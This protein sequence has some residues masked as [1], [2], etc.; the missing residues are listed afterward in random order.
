LIKDK[1]FCLKP[2]RPY[3]VIE[4]ITY[5]SKIISIAIPLRSNINIRF[6][7]NKN[8]YI[9]VNATKHT[10]VEKG[11]VSGWQI[12]KMIPI[13]RG[14]FFETETNNKNIIEAVKI[15]KK[16]RKEL[17]VKCRILLNKFAQNKKIYGAIDFDYYVILIFK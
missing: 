5:K 13:K 3:Y 17:L 10:L 14:L 4:K 8:S 12:L 9:K 16:K 1:E 2:T 11:N 6:Q 7:H 15:I